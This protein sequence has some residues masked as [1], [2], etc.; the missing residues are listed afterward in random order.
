MESSITFLGGSAFATPGGIQT[1]NRTL[2]GALH[3]N[4]L[5]QSGFLTNEMI[6]DFPKHLQQLISGGSGSKR[7]LIIWA[8]NNT[9][10]SSDLILT[11]HLNYSP[12]LFGS[13]RA[14]RKVVTLHAYEMEIP[15]SPIR[16]A[17]LKRMDAYICVSEYSK[18]LALKLGLEEDKMHVCHHGLDVE[19]AEPTASSFFNEVPVI[20]FVGRLDRHYKGHDHLVE[21][22]ALLCERGIKFK[23]VFAGGGQRLEEFR[24][25]VVAKQLQCMVEFRG[26]VSDEEL[27]CLYSNADIFALPSSGEGFGLVYLEAMAHSLPCLAVNAG[28]APEVVIDNE[29]GVCVEHGDVTAIAGALERLI[30]DVDWRRAMGVQGRCRYE[31]NFTVAAFEARLIMLLKKLNW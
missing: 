31:T 22:A 6:T 13:F 4:S 9:V 30:R 12:I 2:L 17:V 28:A 14:Q 29:T 27:K 26:F 19:V 1:F 16:M 21:A 18:R 11:D 25:M 5:L 10:K 8:L 24:Q 15:V 23:M 3:N 7:S 20:L